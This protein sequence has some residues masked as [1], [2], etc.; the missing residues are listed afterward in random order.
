MLVAE[1]IPRRRKGGVYKRGDRWWGSWTGSDGTRQQKPLLAQNYNDAM[2]EVAANRRNAREIRKTGRPA[3]A[4]EPLK[5][6]VEAFLEWQRPR[7]T[8]ESWLRTKG[9]LELP[10]LQELLSKPVHA[11]RREDIDA[12]ATKRAAKRSAGTIYKELGVVK[13]MFNWLVDTKEVLAKSPA[14][15]YEPP[16]G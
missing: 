13:K 10:D 15:K 11:I 4:T 2:D 12:F 14:K 6:Y 8:P 16:C 5:D 3:P 9:V 7:Q 1:V